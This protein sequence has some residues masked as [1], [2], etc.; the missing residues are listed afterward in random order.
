[1][2]HIVAQLSHNA[3][4]WQARVDKTMAVQTFQAVNQE[5]RQ[6]L[7]QEL[8]LGQI[9]F[10]S[11]DLTDAGVVDMCNSFME[12]SSNIKMSQLGHDIQEFLDVVHMACSCETVTLYWQNVYDPG[13]FEIVGSV[14]QGTN[15]NPNPNP[16]I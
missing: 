13:T 3:A 1:M 16:N 9:L 11:Q 7:L 10:M 14:G 4:T 12:S 15:P 2:E 5:T 8:F 6:T